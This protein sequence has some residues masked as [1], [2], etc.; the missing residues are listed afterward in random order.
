VSLHRGGPGSIG[1]AT[2]RISIGPGDNKII[3]YCIE[4]AVPSF[5]IHEE[6]GGILMPYFI[7]V[8]M[9]APLLLGVLA[10]RRW[11]HCKRDGR[12]VAFQYHISDILTGT[13]WLAIPALLIRLSQCNGEEKVFA[14]ILA[15]SGIL[16][17]LV[18]GKTYRL[19][20]RRMQPAPDAVYL[21]VGAFSGLA[22]A[23]GS[24]FAVILILLS[25][26]HGC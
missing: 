4:K 5:K 14:T 19:T 16:A 26:W 6:I 18:C 3:S 23:L 1:F 12:S 20:T 10:W 21:S 2:R 8:C 17:G 22:V 9:V 25:Q 7:M 15:C 24:G 11:R 13:L